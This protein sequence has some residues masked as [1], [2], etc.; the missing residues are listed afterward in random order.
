M[1]RMKE[2]EK[3]NRRGWGW[4]VKEVIGGGIRREIVQGWKP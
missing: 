1:K 4:G 3:E 2:E